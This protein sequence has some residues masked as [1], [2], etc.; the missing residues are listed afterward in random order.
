[1]PRTLSREAQQAILDQDTLDWTILSEY[2]ARMDADA[3]APTSER[4]KSMSGYCT[5]AYATLTSAFAD[6]AR[7]YRVMGVDVASYELQWL[8]RSPSMVIFAE[9]LNIDLVHLCSG[10]WHRL[11]H[12]TIKFEPLDRADEPTSP[13]KQAK[14][15]ARHRRTTQMSA[16]AD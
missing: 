10:V 6:V 16:A 12:G 5:L 2:S 7:T 1:M 9:V 15:R 3:L 4:D 8:S 11:R 13:A 14:A